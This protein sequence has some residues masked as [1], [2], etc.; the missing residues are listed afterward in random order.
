MEHIRSILFF[1][2]MSTQ[3]LGQH[4][5][6]NYQSFAIDSKDVIWM[7]VYHQ[8]STKNLTTTLFEYLKQKGWIHN[9]R[10]EAGDIIA[11]LVNYHPDYKR[12]GGKFMNTSAIIRTGRWTGKVKISFK[13]DKY[14]VILYDL[15]Y[16]ARQTTTGEGKATIVSH[17]ISGTLG[18]FALHN[19]RLSFK[20]SRF[21]DLDILHLSFKDSFTL[22]VNQLIDSDW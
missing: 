11:D 1:A 6:M 20:R 16:D 15:H 7:Q 21:I 22:M 8:D 3:V 5:I 4:G 18:H 17:D 9:I 13:E 12:Y 2:F 19:H 14:R 10:F